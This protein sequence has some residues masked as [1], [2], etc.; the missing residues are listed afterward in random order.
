[1]FKNQIFF[2]KSATLCSFYLS[3]L[4]YDIPAILALMSV[5]PLVS[6]RIYYQ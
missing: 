6:K 2:K 5:S 1:M 3:K 4:G